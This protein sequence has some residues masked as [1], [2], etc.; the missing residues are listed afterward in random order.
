MKKKVLLY[1]LLIHTAFISLSLAQRV[2]ESARSRAA[3]ARAIPKINRIL[4]ANDSLT[5]GSPIFIRVFK[6]SGELEVWM[7]QDSSDTYSLVKT[8][9]ICYF[10][11]KLGPKLRQGDLQAPEGF[12]FV[13]PRRMNPLSSFHLSFDIGYPNAYDRYYN[14]T[15]GFIAIHGNCVSI[16]C[17]A[18]TDPAIEEI[19]TMAAKAL[20]TG[21]RFFRVHVFP[22]RMTQQNME[23]YKAHR[24]INYCKNLKTGYDFFEEKKIPPNVEVR[25]GKY[26]FEEDE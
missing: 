15:G 4:A 25:G 6:A 22:F 13:S 5:L 20:N 14:R 9:P 16:G 1:L 17:L 21:Q 19:F 18:M 7:K 3:I 23:K 26:V 10:S 2:P 11:G 24:W 8:Y 12:Y